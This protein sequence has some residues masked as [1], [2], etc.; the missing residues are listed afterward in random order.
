[1]DAKKLVA[2][3]SLEEKDRILA[4]ALDDFQ[5]VWGGDTLEGVLKTLLHESSK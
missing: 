2:T 3:L 5:D 1:M 4:W